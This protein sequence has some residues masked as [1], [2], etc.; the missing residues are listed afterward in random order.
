MDLNEVKN[1]HVH[2][3]WAMFLTLLLKKFGIEFP[4][5]GICLG[6]VVEA[7]QKIFKKEGWLIAD[8]LLDISFWSLGGIMGGILW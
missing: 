7:Y 3:F 1:Q 6:I 8:R 2:L 4:Y 5:L